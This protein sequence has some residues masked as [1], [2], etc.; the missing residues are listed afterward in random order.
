MKTIQLKLLDEDN[1]PLTEVAL[2]DYA[3][4]MPGEAVTEELDNT[5]ILTRV[6]E[7]MDAVFASIR[8]RNAEPVEPPIHVRIRIGDALLFAAECPD[9]TITIAVKVRIHA[10][11]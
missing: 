4:P 11:A 10:E 9:P 1:Q 2:E 7:L 8:Q 3:V 6:A 5:G